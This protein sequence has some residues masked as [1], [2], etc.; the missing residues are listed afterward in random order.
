MVHTANTGDTVKVHYTGRYVTGE[1]F[2][3]S[4]GREPLV[5]TIG[6][7]EVIEGFDDAVKGM[8]IGEQKSVTVSPEHGYGAYNEN[9]VIE[10]PTQYIPED[11]S[12][13][14]GLEL[15]IV[16]ENDEEVLVVVTEVHDEFIRLDANHPLAGKTLVFDIELLGIE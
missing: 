13:E 7:G 2:D 3:S 4:L 6:S 9:L 8:S 12:P 15:K 16:D 14:E 1:E 5:F 10:M 11:I